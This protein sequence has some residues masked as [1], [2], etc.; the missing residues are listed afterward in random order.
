MVRRATVRGGRCGRVGR[1]STG[2]RP[3]PAAGVAI[4]TTARDAGRGVRWPH[5]NPDLQDRRIS[6]TNPPCCGLRQS[7][8]SVTIRTNERTRPWRAACA[9][10]LRGRGAVSLMG[11]SGRRY[12]HAQ[13]SLGGGQDHACGRR[14]WPRGR[15][16]AVG[17][18]VRITPF[19]AAVFVATVGCPSPALA[20]A[21]GS[22]IVTTAQNGFDH[23][24]VIPTSALSVWW[25]S[26]PYTWLGFY[27]G[28]DEDPCAGP[29]ST[30]VSAVNGQGWSFTPIWEGLQSACTGYAHT[31]PNG[32]NGSD[33]SDGESSA[34]N[35]VTA[36][37]GLGFSVGSIIYYDLEG[38]GAQDSPSCVTAAEN[39]ISGWT[40]KLHTLGWSAGVYGSSCDSGLAD[41]PEVDD[42]WPALWD[43][44][45]TTWGIECISSGTWETDRRLHQYDGNVYHSWGGTSTYEVDEDCALGQVAGTKYNEDYHETNDEA[46]G[47]GEDGPCP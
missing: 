31:F 25:S 8:T 30:W 13:L 29:D 27:V 12:P 3:T 11:V 10:G 1:V 34:E 21:P 23:C 44:S 5:A 24:G 32:A 46:S 19:V 39:Y 18:A 4:N 20:A 42:V 15:R 47:E 38:Y 17:F 45:D 28:G 43:N 22:A 33:Y 26:S 37:R 16:L 35:A 40:D 2:Q 36:A 9:G 6:R 7:Q 41:Y 14:R